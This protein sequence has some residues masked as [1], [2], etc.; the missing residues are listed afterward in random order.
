MGYHSA[1]YDHYWRIVVAELARVTTLYNTTFNSVR[2]G[3]YKVDSSTI[4][5]FAPDPTR[6]ADEPVTL[7]QYHSADY[8]RDGRI[9]DA[10]L[11]RVTEL[12]AYAYEDV[13]NLSAETRTGQYHDNNPFSVDGFGLGPVSLSAYSFDE[14]HKPTINSNWLPSGYVYRLR[15]KFF[16]GTAEGFQSATTYNNNGLVLDTLPAPGVYRVSLRWV[17]YATNGFEGD[18]DNDGVVTQDD[19]DAIADVVAGTLPQPTGSQYMRAD[20]APRS[21]LGSG[22]A[23]S[24]ADQTQAGRYRDQLDPYTLVGGPGT[25]DATPTY[26]N[27]LIG[28][29]QIVTVTVGE[30]EA[31]CTNPNSTKCVCGDPIP[32]ENE[33]K[34]QCFPLRV[35]R[36]C[37]APDLPI[38]ACNDNDYQTIYDPSKTPPFY[39]VSALRDSSCEV[40]TDAD[41][42]PIMTKIS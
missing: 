33:E 7:T 12:Y 29:E 34:A 15:A 42:Y 20:C 6:A 24:I 5:G 31:P 40:I 30:V 10:E 23:I 27:W 37:N 21:T 4:D 8:N 9:D 32:I 22:N 1:D 16:D 2:T 39:V 18:Y 35:K 41:G 14:D 25:P 13:P 11:E 19:V 38:P 17:Q 36:S 26:V 3:C 28:N